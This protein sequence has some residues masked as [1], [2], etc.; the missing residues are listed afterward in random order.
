[1]KKKKKKKKIGPLKIVFYLVTIYI[2][3]TVF[4]QN[5]LMKGLEVKRVSLEK[6][7]Y[8]LEKEVEELDEEL[9]DSDSLE[10]IERVARDEL[11]MVKPREIMVIDK[12]KTKNGF[13]RLFRGDINWH[14]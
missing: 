14:I 9:K 12:E 7:I 10:F 1:M 13:F 6:D 11:G 2:L 3:I 5:K 4:N 8:T